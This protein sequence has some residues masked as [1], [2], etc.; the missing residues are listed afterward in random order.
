MFEM[1]VK[2]LKCLKCLLFLFCQ[3]IKVNKFSKKQ[4]TCVPKSEITNNVNKLNFLK[5]WR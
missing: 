5:W 1:F 4:T 3:V 2:S